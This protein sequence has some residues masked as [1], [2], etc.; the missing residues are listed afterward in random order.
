MYGRNQHN[1]EKQLSSNQELFFLMYNCAMDLGK[2]IKLKHFSI[3][4][5]KRIFDWTFSH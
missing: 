5:F 4:K 3:F 1:I 2:Y